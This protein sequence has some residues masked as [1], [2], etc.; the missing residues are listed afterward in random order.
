MPILKPRLLLM[1]VGALTAACA[2]AEPGGLAPGGPVAASQ[3]DAAQPP[4]PATAAVTPGLQPDGSYVLSPSELALDCKK[5]T[6]RTLVRILQIRDYELSRKSSF[7][8]RQFQQVAKPLFGGTSHG[9]DPDADYRRDRAV[10]EAY[11]RR[12]AER[13]CK[14]FDLVKELQPKPAAETPALVKK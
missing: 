14:S 10:V 3:E 2:G 6:G 12:L 5:L 13:R 11:N 1:A 7:A 9:A 8:S 4:A